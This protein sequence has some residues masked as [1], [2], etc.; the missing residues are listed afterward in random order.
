V[1]VPSQTDMGDPHATVPGLVPED[2]P[3]MSAMELFLVL[4]GFIGMASIGV[5]DFH[6]HPDRFG[7][8]VDALLRH[9]AMDS[10]LAGQ[11]RDQL[12]ADLANLEDVMVPIQIPLP[13]GQTL[14]VTIRQWYP[15]EA[16][17]VCASCTAVAAN[18]YPHPQ[19][20]PVTRLW[21]PDLAGRGEPN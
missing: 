16:A 5:A 9:K 8:V 3:P 7:V 1:S 10:V 21:T 14:S 6:M 18:R 11:I 12:M 19:D 20:E 2:L 17:A 13:A 4:Q 15:C